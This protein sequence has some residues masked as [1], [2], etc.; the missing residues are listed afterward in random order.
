MINNQ[1]VC[2]ELGVAD[3]NDGEI[4]W[5]HY[6]L[7]CR[8]YQLNRKD[9]DTAKHN[10]KHVHGFD[11]ANKRTDRSQNELRKLVKQLAEKATKYKCYIGYKGGEHEKKLL[12][13]LGY[14]YLAYNL[15]LEDCPKF[16]ILYQLC[17]EGRKQYLRTLGCKRHRQVTDYKTGSIKV[18]HCP[19]Q[20]VCCFMWFWWGYLKTGQTTESQPGA[21]WQTIELTS[22]LSSEMQRQCTPTPE[23]RE[24]PIPQD[25]QLLDETVKMLEDQRSINSF[26]QQKRYL[27]T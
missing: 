22:G 18:A 12:T 26:Y 19:A 27:I 9:K 7:P 20:E 4:S 5:S 21:S 16:E 14:G 15:E 17:S 25:H 1:F 10:L 11:F 13:S 24:L 3:L 2:K 23:L 6:R 8:R